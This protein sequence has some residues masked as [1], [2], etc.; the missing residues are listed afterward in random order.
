MFRNES[1][2]PNVETNPSRSVRMAHDVRN[3]IY[4]S[5]AYGSH[6]QQEQI[7]KLETSIFS[8]MKCKKEYG[9]LKKITFNLQ[10]TYQQLLKQ[11]G[12]Q[13]S[14]TKSIQTRID[15]LRSQIENYIVNLP[16]NTLLTKPDSELTIDQIIEI[17]HD[18][19]LDELHMR[20]KALSSI[21]HPAIVDAH[22]YSKNQHTA[23]GIF[24]EE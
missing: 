3:I 20:Q 5:Y 17:I 4:T 8:Y 18:F 16:F 21:T 10:R 23:E 9:F 24:T 13:T 12:E 15:E 22:N 11:D 2:L 14:P 6:Q 7:Y 1:I 19:H